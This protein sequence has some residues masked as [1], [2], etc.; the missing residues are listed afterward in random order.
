MSESTLM[1]L[2]NK[3]AVATPKQILTAS[4]PLL[5]ILTTYYLLIHRARMHIL[6]SKLPKYNAIPSSSLKRIAD[7][8]TLH[9]LSGKIDVAIIG[10]GIGA[11]SNAVCLSRQGFKVAVFEQN[12]TVGGCTHT[13]E[14][15]GYEFD[16]GVHYVGESVGC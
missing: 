10:S 2:W 15:E 11:L 8:D 6:K 3:A 7:K 1:L 5:F 13:F 14:K 4:I 9:T 16:V 12:E